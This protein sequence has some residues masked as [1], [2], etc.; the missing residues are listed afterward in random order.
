MDK[1]EKKG[2][3]AGLIFYSGMLLPRCR[4]NLIFVENQSLN[5]GTQPE[6]I[7]LANVYSVST[8]EARQPL[9]AFKLTSIYNIP[10][11]TMQHYYEHL[12]P[13]GRTFFDT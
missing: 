1:L 10:F 8:I 5:L 3:I 9:F 4:D 6:V 12:P 2:C 7:A 13:S 11:I